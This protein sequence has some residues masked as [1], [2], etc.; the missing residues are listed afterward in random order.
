MLNFWVL[1]GG[2]IALFAAYAARRLS[3]RS[4][5]SLSVPSVSEQWLAERRGQTDEH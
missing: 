1:A 2:A 4:N 3:R 5:T